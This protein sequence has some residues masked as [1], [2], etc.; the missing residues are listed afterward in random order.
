[1]PRIERHASVV[2]E[3]NLAHGTGRISAGTGAFEGLDYS[4]AARVGK[5][6]EGKTSPEELLAAAHAGCFA[7]SLAGELTRAGTPPG[8]LD[9]RTNVV[10]DEVEGKG[11]LIV[12]SE[13]RVRA[14]VAGID[15]DAFRRVVEE[16][17]GGCPFSTLIKASATVSI[18]A[19]LEG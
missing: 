17:D 16:A 2:W 11:H 7:T 10:M 19:E 8:K 9:I 18:D 3:G 5:G 14:R 13:V 15:E 4:I 6:D 12:A 1:V